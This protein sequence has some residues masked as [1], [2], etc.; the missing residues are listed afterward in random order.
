[1]F[2]FLSEGTNRTEQNETTNN[3]Q[4]TNKQNQQRQTN[5]ERDETNETH[6]RNPAPDQHGLAAHAAKSLSASGTGSWAALGLKTPPE[7][8]PGLASTA[9]TGTAAVLL[10]GR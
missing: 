4:T 10:T 7:K 8:G 3:Q 2:F 9:P 6:T 5:N 1:M